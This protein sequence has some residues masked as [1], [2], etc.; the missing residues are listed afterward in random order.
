MGFNYLQC[1]GFWETNKDS[2]TNA[3]PIYTCSADMLVVYLS[4]LMTEPFKNENIISVFGV[5]SSFSHLALE[6]SRQK[7]RDTITKPEWTH[8]FFFYI[9]F[10]YETGIQKK[11]QRPLISWKFWTGYIQGKRRVRA[12]QR[13]PAYPD[14]WNTQVDISFLPMLTRDYFGFGDNVKYIPKRKGI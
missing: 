10:I 11:P 2:S 4:A 12:F 5:V 9:S 6:G 7:W 8:T 3:P 14:T 13:Y 1:I